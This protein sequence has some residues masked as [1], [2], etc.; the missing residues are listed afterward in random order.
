MRISVALVDELR[1]A[2]AEWL[3]QMTP[4]GVAALRRASKIIVA[5]TVEQMQGALGHH[6][7]KRAPKV[8][9]SMGVQVD[10]RS[11]GH[12]F[13]MIWFKR[14]ILAAHEIGAT[15][16]G[17]V[18]RPREK[19]VMAWGGPPG[20]P[21]THFAKTVTRRTRTLRRRPMLEPGY[22]RSEAEVLQELTSSYDETFAKGG[23]A[24]AI[25]ERIGG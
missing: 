16:P 21:H 8:A 2:I 17:G 14:G 12:P 13:A 25:R 11:G 15:I 23:T 4:T 7:G 5:H 18:E 3:A 20:G 19:K 24:A 6:S 22:R 1:P 10:R 9:K